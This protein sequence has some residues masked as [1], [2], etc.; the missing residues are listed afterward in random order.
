MNFPNQV[1]VDF[2][3]EQLTTN[4]NRTLTNLGVALK[5]NVNNI[6]KL[7]ISKPVKQILLSN[8]T[9][10][11]NASVKKL[12]VEYNRRKEELIAS[13]KASNKQALLVGIN[14]TNTAN[15]LYGCINDTSNMQ[16]LLS[17]KL[18]YKVFTLLTDNT[19]NKPT[20]QNIMN[21]L[22]KLLVESKSGDNL[23]FLFSGHGTNTSDVNKDELDGLDELIVPLD[24]TSVSSCILDDD[25]YALIRTNLKKDVKLLM[26]FDSCFSGTI[27][28]LKYNYMTDA[29]NKMIINSSETDTIGDV[30]VISGCKDDQT[31]ADAYV[32]YVNKNMYA[33]AM[34]Y[35]FLTAVNELGIGVSLFEL[36]KRMRDILQTN[37]Y[38][39]IPQLSGGK[40]VDIM[41]TTVF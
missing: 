41:Q 37:G 1:Y 2:Q 32:N 11:Y 28:D 27:M 33:G 4:Y 12:T 22:S 23:F 35:S 31:S 40:L 21:E 20:K 16:Q 15:E 24:A 18:N 8:T 5:A 3:L 34:T 25:L 29:N 36:L 14:Y 19:T 17:S 30:F 6:N 38:E 13:I 9:Q 26:L 10:N 39:Q 7:S